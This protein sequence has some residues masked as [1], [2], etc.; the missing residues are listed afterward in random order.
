ML[1]VKDIDVGYGEIQ[2]LHK[3]SLRLDA[4][5]I[6][7]IIGANGAGKTTLIRSIMGLVKVQSGSIEYGDGITLS[8][9]STHKI[10]RAG[11]T[12]VPEGRHI[13]P[14]LSVQDNLE[15]GA[16]S[17]KITKAEYEKNLEEVYV[18]FPRLKER[19]KQPGGT[20][21]G[22]EQQMLA[23]GRGMMNNPRILLLDEPSLGLAPI[24]VDEMFDCI[25][26]IKKVHKIPI[27]L[28]EQNAYSALEISA[29]AYV[30]E[31]GHIVQHGPS[32]QLLGDEA[33]IKAY[34]GG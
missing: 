23:I 18:T 4:D 17:R 7:A 1:E 30:L 21:S 11:I 9:M 32:Q 15:M 31:L 26:N 12:C 27:L 14:R 20:L 5:E 2:V 13:F 24:V 25:L 29:K 34:L 10:A 6:V 3:V 33:V 28:V 22:G 16:Y 8:K 19:C